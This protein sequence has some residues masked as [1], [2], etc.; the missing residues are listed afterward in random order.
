MGKAGLVLCDYELNAVAGLSDF[1]LSF[2]DDLFVNN[3]ERIRLRCDPNLP[4]L[5]G[6]CIF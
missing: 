3:Q 2:E 4:K 6:P 5:G 1:S